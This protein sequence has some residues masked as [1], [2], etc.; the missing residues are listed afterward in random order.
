MRSR[1]WW[2]TSPGTRSGPPSSGTWDGRSRR[3]TRLG[4]DSSGASTGQQEHR[5]AARMLLLVQ[6]DRR[7]RRD[8]VESDL[9]GERLEPGAVEA[10]MV[11]ALGVR[12]VERAVLR[13]EIGQRD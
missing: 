3:S 10:V 12:A 6:H 1:R 13:V 7:P 5:I 8:L 4:R 9:A 11:D 2:P